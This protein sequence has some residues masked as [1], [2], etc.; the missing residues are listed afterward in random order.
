M[1]LNLLKVIDVSSNQGFIKIAP[2]DCDAVITKATGGNSYVNHCCDYVIQ[3]CIK[4][5]K[6]FGFYHYAHEYGKVNLP[7][8]EADFFIKNTKNYFKRG[9]VVL[10]YE[11]PI[12]GRNYTKTDINW[13]EQFIEYVHQ[14]TGVYCLLYISKSLLYGTGDWSRVA[15]ISGL[16]FAQYADNNRTGWTKTPWSDHKPTSPF[17]VVMD[18]YTSTGRIH[19]YN[20]NL[21]LSIFYGDKNTWNAY[22]NPS[23]QI[24]HKPTEKTKEVKHMDYLTEFAKDVIKGKYG[25]GQHRKEN[26]YNAVQKKVEQLLK[27]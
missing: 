13:I 4:L 18:Q 16:W 8:K 19:G 17:N 22:A 12:N 3:Q 27:K 24:I 14:K 20:G 10:D 6:P 11:V 2:I 15:K 21:D 25:N 26:I 1:V 7:E 23:K 5:N 9:L